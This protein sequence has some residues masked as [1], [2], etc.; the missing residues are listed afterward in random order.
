MSPS[1]VSDK[2]ISERHLRALYDLLPEVVGN[3]YMPR[4]SKELKLWREVLHPAGVPDIR[5]IKEVGGL[6]YKVNLGD[7]LGCDI[8]YGYF[9]ER[10]DHAL[11]MA[12]TF[13]GATVADI[14]AN[15]GMYA[16]SAALRVGATGRVLAFEPDER[17]A[18]LLE[19]N[20]LLNHLEARVTC[21][22][23]CVGDL[24]G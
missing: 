19:E 3:A 12:L 4:F 23:D 22:H 20:V 13:P 11:F 14:G 6:E 17:S 21:L 15:Y 24:N 1:H 18:H 7:H 8:Y 9:Q 10:W 2:P 16:L 5:T